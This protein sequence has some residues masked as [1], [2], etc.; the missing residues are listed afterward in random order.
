VR[1]TGSGPWRAF[2]VRSGWT[3]AYLVAAAVLTLIPGIRGVARSGDNGFNGAACTKL[4][5]ETT[6][7]G[8]QIV[9]IPGATGPTLTVIEDA[10]AYWRRCDQYAVGFPGFAIGGGQGRR[11]EIVIDKEGPGP[12]YCGVFSGETVVIYRRAV[13]ADSVVLCPPVDR[14]LAHEL[15]HVLGLADI[16][17]RAGCP[18]FIMSEIV[19]NRPP[20]QRVSNEE[21]AAVAR[22][23]LTSDERAPGSGAS[24][25]DASAGSAT[26]ARKIP[27]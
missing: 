10:I 13:V 9:L 8:D 1:P 26:I 25:Q 11:V 4:L 6:G 12:G 19:G 15:G 16:D 23:W 27:R 17:G 7:L 20:L 22:R 24:G 18:T 21:C 14:L 2:G 3:R 5:S